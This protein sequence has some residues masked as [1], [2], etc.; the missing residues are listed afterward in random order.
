MRLPQPNESQLRTL[1]RKLSTDEQVSGIQ[2]PPGTGKSIV[3]AYLAVLKASQ[4]NR[5]LAIAYQN[6]SIDQLSSYIVSLLMQIGPSLGLP[7]A[8]AS[9]CRVGWPPRISL[10]MM[11]YYR[12]DKG[13]KDKIIVATTAYSSGRLAKS[14]NRLQK[15]VK[16]G[17]D[18]ILI[19]ESGQIPPHQAWIALE[20]LSEGADSIIAIGDDK[21]IFPQSPN[22][23]KEPSILVNLRRMN[24]ASIDMLE[25]TYRLPDPGLTMTSN[26][27]YDG[28]LRAPIEVRNRRLELR[29]IVGS[30]PYAEALDPENSLFY[31][32]V[33]RDG[34]EWKG[35]SYVNKAQA[36]VA[37]KLGSL[38]LKGG[39]LPDE[40]ALIAPYRGQRQFIRRKLIESGL[41]LTCTTV[42]GM[43]GRERKT[44]IFMTTRSN[45]Y[46][47]LGF[48]K[49]QPEI[50]NVG[51]TRHRCKLII[52]GDHHDVFSDGSPYSKAMFD[53]MDGQGLVNWVDPP[54]LFM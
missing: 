38:L 15:L 53:F 54:S 48:L 18:T 34:E 33:M 3:G 27:F 39:C 22:F 13:A 47:D 37:L 11:P 9:F 23:T 26:L 51:T 6:E 10:E 36:S 2:G 43:L 40:I 14:L 21:Q 49:S 41:P 7:S 17:F 4:G 31:V 8:H 32:G 19:E 45:R 25:I 28:R 35:N 5:V 30:G 1:G 24:P 50:L 12:G 20:N 46:S 16:Q 42:H 52:V 29:R 44:I